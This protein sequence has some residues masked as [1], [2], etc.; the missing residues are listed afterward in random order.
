MHDGE[1]DHGECEAHEDHEEG[2]DHEDDT[3]SCRVR[4]LLFNN[5]CWRSAFGAASSFILTL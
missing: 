1:E 4:P 3:R 5:S 2:E